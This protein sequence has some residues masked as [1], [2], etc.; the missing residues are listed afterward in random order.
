MTNLVITTPDQL[1]E[2]LDRITRRA[3]AACFDKTAATVAPASPEYLK[4]RE[5]A[6]LLSVSTSTIDNYVR[7]GRLPKYPFGAKQVRFKRAD[8]LNLLTSK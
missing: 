3:V 6:Q 7:Q 5:A 4:K 8:V 1:E 2:L